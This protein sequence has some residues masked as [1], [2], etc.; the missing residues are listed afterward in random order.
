[1][2]KFI[3]FVSLIV[4]IVAFL[5]LIRPIALFS[6]TM[7]IQ[8][9]SGSKSYNEDLNEEECQ[10]NGWDW[11]REGPRPI[12][13]CRRPAKDG[14]KT[15]VSGFQCEYGMCLARLSLRKPMV[16]GIGQCSKYMRVYGCFRDVHFG[17]GGEMLCVD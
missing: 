11:I 8:A 10:K 13:G 3:V 9:L 12:F 14:G 16:V 7:F 15:C 17:I 2:K 4:S 5:S 6:D 1:M